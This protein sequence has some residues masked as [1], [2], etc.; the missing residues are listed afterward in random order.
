MTLILVELVLVAIGSL[1][2][3][4]LGLTLP[5]PIL[6][7]GVLS[8]PETPLFALCRVAPVAGLASLVL[9][10][11]EWVLLSVMT[12]PFVRVALRVLFAPGEPGESQ[13]CESEERKGCAN[14]SV[15]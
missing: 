3:A 13:H 5:A 7:A 14:E 2:V 15:E 12:V 11:F 10:P 4:H 1:R 9:V 8:A 6:V